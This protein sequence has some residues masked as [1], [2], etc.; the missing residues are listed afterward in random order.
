MAKK[1]T[2]IKIYIL[3]AVLAAI[4]LPGFSKYNQLRSQNILLRNKVR[5]LEG[6][7][8]DLLN[9]VRRLKT[10]SVYVERKARE[11]M[12]VVKKGEIVYRVSEE[13]SE[14]KK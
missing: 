3:L 7:K 12:G 4:F 1:K 11:K 6:E 10:D 8:K 2:L 9:E 14:K 13:E 5:G